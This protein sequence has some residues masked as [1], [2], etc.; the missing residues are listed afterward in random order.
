MQVV[1][2]IHEGC[3]EEIYLK[4]LLHLLKIYN[5]STLD[6]HNVQGG[7]PIKLLEKFETLIDDEDRN[8]IKNY[9]FIMDADKPQHNDVRDDILAY[10]KNYSNFVVVSFNPCIEMLLIAHFENN[11]NKLQEKAKIK[12]LV[13]KDILE[14]TKTKAKNVTSSCKQ[15]EKYL[16]YYHIEGYSKANCIKNF[17]DLIGQEEISNAYKQ[18][19]SLQ[20][21]ISFIKKII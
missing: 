2:I 16:K 21:L 19:K 9:L 12:K 18:C 10:Q 5:T 15:S 11:I 4:H 6:F 14:K 13:T 20:N 8:H 1:T 17:Q 3:T 7:G